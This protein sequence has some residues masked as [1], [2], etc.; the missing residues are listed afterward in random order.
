MIPPQFLQDL[1]NRSDIIEVVGR[2]V[3]LKKAGIHHKGLCP[4]HH[5][6]T[7]SFTISATR[8]TYH[9]FGCGAHG[10]A[11]GFLMQHCGMSFPD[12][13][14]DLAQRA[15]MRVPQDERS[16]EDLERAAAL[17]KQQNSLSNLLAKAAHHYQQQIT[18]HS[19]A[20]AYL[21]QRGLSSD[22][23]QR[24]GLGYAPDGWRFLSTVIPDYDNPQW[25]NC[26]L[27][28]SPENEAQPLQGRK[29]YDRFRNRIMFPIRSVQGDV[30]GFGG[31]V[32][33]AGEPKYL[34]SPETPVF[35][36]GRELYGLFEARSEIRR[37]GYTLVVEGYMDVVALA[38]S[39][40]SNA[41]ATL[42]TACTA[43]HISKLFRFT[44][45][46]IFSFDG[47]AAGMR[48]AARALEISL[49]FATD[50]RSVRF[51]FLPSEHDPDSYVREHGRDAFEACIVESQPL[52]RQL[53]T[54]AQQDCD[55]TTA[56][57][58]AR[59][60]VRARPLWEALPEGALKRQLQL[61]LAK[62]S[63]LSLSDLAELWRSD[64]RP[65]PSPSTAPWPEAENA[66]QGRP[67]S[68]GGP[69]S[70]KR[71]RLFSR[72][73]PPRPADHA[74]RLLLL[75]SHWLDK[76]AA[77]DHDLLAQLPSPHG[78]LAGWLERQIAEHGPMAW[79][80]L[81][82]RLKE[83][84]TTELVERLIPLSGLEDDLQFQDLR[85]SL[86]TLWIEKLSLQQTELAAAAGH[87]PSALQRYR[88]ISL[89]LN[90][91]KK[92]IYPLN[93]TK[94]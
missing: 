18:K 19:Q 64:T 75:N 78:E 66:R 6:K 37:K 2:H 76:L 92:T 67:A 49:P 26:G 40:Y 1:L 51:L 93:T 22:V 28:I 21:N 54:L 56:E 83:Q 7:P 33:D 58:R 11:I 86:D 32:I 16:P 90:H 53:T 10:N 47:D 39:G 45:N 61:D 63:G 69:V 87:D 44:D 84:F 9:C 14:N 88:E 91:L 62:I 50:A 20:S 15:G 25:V 80:A 23:T 27:V 72:T 85:R 77:D 31:R 52:S 79:A 34:N 30:I 17:K 60:L 70:S 4:F 48:A 81:E 38:Q 43:D 73:T 71:S 94:L 13:V 57:G 55:L 5:E 65:P 82:P 89:R 24:F 3:E 59:F 12:A 74:L 46:I 36:K 35:S 29:R 68:L 41:V 8:Q 42:G